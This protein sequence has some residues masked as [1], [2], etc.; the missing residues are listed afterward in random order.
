MDDS[1]GVETTSS[2]RPSGSLP[3]FSRA[4]DMFMPVEDMDNASQE[5]EDKFFVPTY[6]E[7]STYMQRLREAHRA[8]LIARKEA[9]RTSAVSPST[10]GM[11]L[12]SA[13]LPTGSH[14]GM[15]HVVIERPTPKDDDEDV[16]LPLP[17]QWS[18]DDVAAGLDIQTDGLGL[19]FPDSKSHHEREHEACAVRTDHHIPPQCGIYYF[20][21][22]ILSGKRDD[23]YIAIG[24]STKTASIDR[25]VGWEPESWGYHCDDGRCF[26]G[27]KI[28]RPFGPTFGTGDV[29]GCGINFRD[30]TAFYTRNGVK[31]GTAFQEVLRGKLYPSV[32]LKKPGEQISVN[33]GQTPFV[34]NIDDVVREQKKNIQQQIMEAD[35]S[36]LEH[37]MGETDLI[38]NL[39]M[40][41]L[42]HDGYVETARAFAEDLRIQNEALRSTSNNAKST[43]SLRDDEDANNRQRI[44]RAVLDGDI[45]QALEYMEKYYPQVL[46]ENQT[47]VFKLRCRKFIELV[48]KAAHINME[49]E[50]RRRNGNSN[51]DAAMDIDANG[52]NGFEQT[53]LQELEIN[54]LVY[55]QELQ[56]EYA[57]DSRKEITTALEQIWA[58]VAYPNPLKEPEVAH[59]LDRKGRQA[60]AEELNAAILS[61][62]GKSSQAALEK[63]YAQTTVL[64]E[65]LR[66]DGGE[67][68]FLSIKDVLEGVSQTESSE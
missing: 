7:S 28:G 54:M 40:Q 26:T 18:R 46:Q 16:L 33:F 50:G 56:R 13:S 34:F 62:L 51:G 68:A 66:T 63:I 24:F 25:P 55:G 53:E 47:V 17:T 5:P 27:Q 37:G 11:H 42:Q 15:S 58:L 2:W 6:L 22:Q 52:T 35:T 12:R 60:V 31:L 41:F 45:D 8:K 21:V 38:H 9:K 44:R 57:G 29:I 14:R 23:T 64:L 32:S 43:I 39:V 4:F 48:R 19:K 59:L 30:R 10:G 3:S 61:S 49:A 67:G 36:S 20:E 65:E 1:G